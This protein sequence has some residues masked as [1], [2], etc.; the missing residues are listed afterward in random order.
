MIAALPNALSVLRI[1][2]AILLLVTRNP[3]EFTVCYLICGISDVLDG[4]AARRWRLESRLGAKLDS[5][6]DL[7]FGAVIFY[8]IYSR[9]PH[10]LDGWIPFFIGGVVLVRAVNVV[11]T[12]LRF[13]QWGM[14]HTWGNKAAGL[15]LYLLL[16]VCILLRKVPIGI[17]VVL[18][19]AA[20]LSA[21][22]ET[23]IL[24][25]AKQYQPNRKSLFIQEKE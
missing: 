13:R 3:A 10:L 20:Y 18:L 14:L 5:L 12:R 8:L 4:W 11:I 22:E 23:V 6:G 21:A 24:L 19:A 16:P 7:A 17:A 15:L 9:N 1:L 25:V 2:F